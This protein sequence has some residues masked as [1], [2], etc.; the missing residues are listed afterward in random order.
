MLY[1]LLGQDDFS[2]R[3][4]LQAAHIAA[5][6]GEIQ[7]FLPE[8]EGLSWPAFLNQD[9]FSKP[10]TFVVSGGFKFLEKQPGDAA[11][12]GF[13]EKPESGFLA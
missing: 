10:K 8:T 12:G 5:K 2:K 6:A 13:G 11:P 1:L 4:Y 3:E 7:V 9:L